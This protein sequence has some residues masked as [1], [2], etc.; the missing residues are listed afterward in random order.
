LSRSVEDLAGDISLSLARNP[1]ARHIERGNNDME[2]PDKNS[3]TIIRHRI[4]TILAARWRTLAIACVVGLV[5]GVLYLNITAKSYT[6]TMVIAPVLQDGTSPASMLGNSALSALSRNPFSQEVS[7]LDKFR[8]MLISND[9]AAALL[10]QPEVLAGVYRNMWDPKARTWRHPSGPIYR[11]SAALKSLL[12]RPGWKPPSAPDL[13]AY[14]VANVKVVALETN[15]LYS[16]TYSNRSPEFARNFLLALYSTADDILRSRERE[17]TL[18]YIN[19]LNNQISTVT[20]TDERSALITIL[21]RQEQMLMVSGAGVPYSAVILETPQ[22][23]QKPSSPNVLV[24]VFV[25]PLLFGLIALAAIYF[26]LSRF[27]PGR[28]STQEH[29]ASPAEYY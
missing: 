14:V 12:N 27:L 29:N 3:I 4:V 5:V 13:K 1:F 18:K 10:Q 15:G 23:P 21:T 8:Q 9:T 17:K 6:A 28:Q 26:R 7:P 20:N 16:V 2:K 24:S 11:I 22:V 25:F 19:F